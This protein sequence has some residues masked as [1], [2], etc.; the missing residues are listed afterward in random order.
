MLLLLSVILQYDVFITAV[1]N[2]I[3]VATVIVAGIVIVAC[4]CC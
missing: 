2:V 1:A 3:A 4:C